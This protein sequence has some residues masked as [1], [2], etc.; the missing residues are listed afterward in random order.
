MKN[1]LFNLKAVRTGSYKAEV[2]AGAEAETNS[3]SSTTLLKG[4]VA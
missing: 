3:F 2:G 4:T 1:R